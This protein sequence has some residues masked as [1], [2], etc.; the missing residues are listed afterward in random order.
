MR[1][2]RL[3]CLLREG[4]DTIDAVLYVV[5]KLGD[6][7]AILG[8]DHQ[9]RQRLHGIGLYALDAIKVV[10][11]LLDFHHDAQFNFLW[12]RT[13]IGDGDEYGLKVEC[14]EKCPLYAECATQSD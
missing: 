13:G 3:F 11:R 2:E 7:N 4:V 8:L 14:G 12:R 6:G 9:S 10:D 5:E 1:D